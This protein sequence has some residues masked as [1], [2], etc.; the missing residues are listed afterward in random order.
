MSADEYALAHAN[1]DEGEKPLLEQLWLAQ[2]SRAFDAGKLAVR[3]TRG[4]VIALA[5]PPADHA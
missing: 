2:K 4:D 5:L 3:A 1:A